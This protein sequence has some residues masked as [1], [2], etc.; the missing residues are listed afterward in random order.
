MAVRDLVDLRVLYLVVC[1]CRRVATET[2]IVRRVRAM[3]TV[4]KQIVVAAS[5]VR[6]NVQKSDVM[7]IAAKAGLRKQ[8]TTRVLKGHR[9]KGIVRAL[10]DLDSVAKEDPVV[11]VVRLVDWH[12]SE[13][14]IRIAISVCRR[15]NWLL[16]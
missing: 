6:E 4:P 13:N 12:S 9:V 1:P 10:A 11:P 15:T 8:T 5:V 3:G 2:P 7:P 14:W 16:P